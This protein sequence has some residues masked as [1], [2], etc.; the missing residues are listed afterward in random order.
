MR[1]YDSVEFAFE[2]RF[3]DNWYLRSSY[4]WSRL[5][6]NYSGLSQSD[7]N[8]RTS[9][10]VGR[11]CDYP[12]MMFQ[13]GGIAGARSAGDRSS[14]PVQG[15]VHLP[16]QLRHE[17]RPEPVRRERPAGD[18]RNRHL[19]RPNNLPG[20]VPRARQ[21]RP[22]ADVLADRPARAARASAWRRPSSCSSSFNVLNLFNQD[23]AVVASS[24]P[25][26]RPT[27]SIPNEALFYAGQQ[28]LASADRQRRTS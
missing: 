8:G 15:A 23:T 1:D 27:A 4:L 26:R 19:S 22:D 10:N 25:T 14:A 24:R 2:K 18:A 17:H 13:D 12:M 9:P 28:T 7:E 6:G 20:A 21:R 3:A 11:L 16:V 5:Y